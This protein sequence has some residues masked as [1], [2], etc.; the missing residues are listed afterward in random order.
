MYF[1]EKQ[2]HAMLERYLALEK[3]IA[4]AEKCSPKMILVQRRQ[5]LEEV[6]SKLHDQRLLVEKLEA[7][8]WVKAREG[9]RKTVQGITLMTLKSL[10]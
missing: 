10:T 4:E 5:Q 1:Q 3:E 2:G 6:E 8:T 9:K 7:E